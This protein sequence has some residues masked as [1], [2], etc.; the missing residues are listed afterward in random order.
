MFRFGDLY[1]FFR[2]L[3]CQDEKF[4]IRYVKEVLFVNKKDTNGVP[5]LSKMVYI[6]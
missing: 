1:T 4:Q 6:G 2:Q 3:K 5:F